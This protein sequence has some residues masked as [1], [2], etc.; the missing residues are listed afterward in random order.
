M[1][2]AKEKI[3]TLL[4]LMSEKQ[5]ENVLAYIK[6]KYRLYPKAPSWEDVEEAEPDEIDLKMLKEIEK[7]PDS[8][9]F[10]SYDQAMKELEL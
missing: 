9:E 1:L 3:V 4:E 2:E 7:D 6:E 5:A 10:V 8:C